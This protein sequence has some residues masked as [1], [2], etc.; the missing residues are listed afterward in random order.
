MSSGP[1]QGA[2]APR[3]AGSWPLNGDARPDAG[4]C[5]GQEASLGFSPTDVNE[6]LTPGVCTHGTCINLE[7]S[8]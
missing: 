1:S 6:C 5:A 3:N 7:G 2:R 4:G 8:F